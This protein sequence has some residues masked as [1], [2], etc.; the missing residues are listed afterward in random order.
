MEIPIL[1]QLAIYLYNLENEA[2]DEI[3][4]SFVFESRKNGFYP[5]PPPPYDSTIKYLPPDIKD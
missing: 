3:D 5:P 2:N 1:N 4:S